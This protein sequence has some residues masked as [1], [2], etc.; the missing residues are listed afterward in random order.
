[1]AAASEGWVTTVHRIFKKIKDLFLA[2]AGSEWY[3]LLATGGARLRNQVFFVCCLM[4][5]PLSNNCCI[6]ALRL[7]PLTCQLAG[8]RLICGKV[9][10]PTRNSVVPTSGANCATKKGAISPSSKVCL[11]QRH[12]IG[13]EWPAA[14]RR[15][16][17]QV[18]HR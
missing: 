10:F 17:A 4:F 7:H 9:Q 16:P 18:G 8:L 6:S 11:L 13:S 5:R 3:V 14:E 12:V 15:M 1:M 2:G